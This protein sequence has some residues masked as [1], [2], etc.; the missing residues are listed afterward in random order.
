MFVFDGHMGANLRQIF[1]LH[2]SGRAFLRFDKE[3]LFLNRSLLQGLPRGLDAKS[4]RSLP[5]L[6]LAWEDQRW[7]LGF[8]HL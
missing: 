6:A 2:N 7:S 5:E 3:Q 1:F 8:P 4:L